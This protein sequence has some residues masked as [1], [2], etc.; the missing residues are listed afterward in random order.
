MDF[1]TSMTPTNVMK[2]ESVFTFTEMSKK[3]VAGQL[4]KSTGH[5]RNDEFKYL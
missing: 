5:V 4:N 3:R 1:C 2:K